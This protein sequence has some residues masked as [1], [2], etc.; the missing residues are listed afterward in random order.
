MKSTEQKLILL[1]EDYELLLSYLKGMYGKTSFDRRNAEEL[2]NELKRAKLVT[3]KDFPADAI[4]INSNVQVKT[5]G[6]DE[7]MEFMLVTPDKANIRDRKISV[8]APVGTALIGFRKG[9]RVKWKVPAGKRTF[10][11]L[12][13]LNENV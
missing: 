1:K 13:V 6:T 2:L 5:E 9:Q 12:D 7:I 3:K 11:I 10:T 4:R 8:M